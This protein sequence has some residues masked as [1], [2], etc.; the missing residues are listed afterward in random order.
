MADIARHHVEDYGIDGYRLDAA[1][2]KNGSWHAS[3][4][5]PAY[6]AGSAAVDLMRAMLAAMRELKPEAVILNEVFGP[7][8]YQVC[9]LVHDNMT[10]G[11]TM[12]L[13]A[14]D[15]GEATAESY[16]LHLADVFD[17]LP[18]GA[19]RVMFTRNHDS[20][21]FYHFNGYTKRTLALDAINAF[22]GI[23]E[24]FSGDP[25]HSPLP[26]D[27][28]AV[29]DHYRHIWGMRRLF[30]ELRRGKIWLR[31]VRSS[32]EMVFAGARQLGERLSV[33][34]VSLSE[35]V[36]EVQIT[37]EIDLPPSEMQAFDAATGAPVPCRLVGSTL[38]LTL[39]PCQAV[40]ARLGIRHQQTGELPLFQTQQRS[41]RVGG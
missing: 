34:V 36:E 8:F 10:M 5:Y 21:W 18:E 25:Q 38:E 31:E 27:D 4:P 12:F 13:E 29:L 1:A 2:Y 16:K 32:Q 19:P 14:V 41:K 15:A 39:Q 17:C 33:V 24:F 3:L 28:P 20:S 40:V 26:E 22:F 35:Q 37:L 7:A 9:D 23:P 11:P 6:R 30:P